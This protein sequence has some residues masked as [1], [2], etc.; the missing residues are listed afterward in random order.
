MQAALL[1]E[2]GQPVALA[3]VDLGE[4]AADEVVVTTAATGICHSD[5][6]IQQGARPIPLPLILGH[7]SSGVV[8][9]VVG[10]AG[11]SAMLAIPADELL[12][13]E[14]RLQG[15]KLGSARFRLDIPLYC[16][17]YLDGRLMLDELVSE[18]I[19]LSE[20]NAGLEALDG[21]G[22]ARTVVVFG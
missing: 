6:T 18:T 4:V 9:R 17:L 8:E 12:L 11:P 15:S 5:R 19:S 13:S 1:E 10:V 22:G 3:E 2:Y 21:D 20:V 14:K 16:R 7:E